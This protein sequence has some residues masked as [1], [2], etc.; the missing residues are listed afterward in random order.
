MEN[1]RK[2]FKYII[3]GI[4]ALII[5]V[6]IF[7]VTTFF[8]KNS[9][10]ENIETELENNNYT[11]SIYKPFHI[12]IFDKNGNV[13]K[14]IENNTPS[15]LNF[16][17]SWMDTCYQSIIDEESDRKEI[18]S[19]SKFKKDLSIK[20]DDY[21]EISLQ[22]SQSSF[23][24]YIDYLHNVS[25]FCPLQANQY[26]WAYEKANEIV[27]EKTISGIK[28]TISNNSN[29]DNYDLSKR[30]YYIKSNP[31]SSYCVITSGESPKHSNLIIKDIKIDNEKNIE[32]IVEEIIRHSSNQDKT[33]NSKLSYPF[34]EIFFSLDDSIEIQGPIKSISI[35]NT[36][37]VEFEKLN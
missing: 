23:C 7:G 14:T 19:D 28:Y 5:I 10:Q 3:L 13:S 15:D 33:K 35:K 8:I 17:F 31:T 12:T 32:I 9:K 27:S 29:L 26:Q 20:F 30:G 34:V 22:N 4:V 11:K 18:Y 36:D 37:G 24:Y 16:L 2:I 1:K 25:C 6:L 21:A